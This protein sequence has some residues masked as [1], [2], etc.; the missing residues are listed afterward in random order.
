MRSCDGE[1]NTSYSSKRLGIHGVDTLDAEVLHSNASAN[2]CLS[3]A[4]VLHTVRSDVVNHS[5]TSFEYGDS[6]LVLVY[7][8]KKLSC[9]S[10]FI[11][12]AYLCA[13]SA[14]YYYAY[15]LLRFLWNQS[16]GKGRI[17][18]I[19]V[20][21]FEKQRC[22]ICERFVGLSGLVDHQRDQRA[23]RA[24]LDWYHSFWG[25]MIINEITAF[26]DTLINDFGIGPPVKAW[27]IY[28]AEKFSADPCC[29]TVASIKKRYSD[30]IGTLQA[31]GF[32][33]PVKN[34]SFKQATFEDDVEA[35]EMNNRLLEKLSFEGDC[36]A[37]RETTD[38]EKSEGMTYEHLALNTRPLESIFELID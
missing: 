13:D 31:S 20:D 15:D 38:E 1:Q 36:E 16:I 33:K 17:V 10:G 26:Y 8:A 4:I 2:S 22:T 30:M 32:S 11:M 29:K 12:P 3:P 18:A 37:V 6:S 21:G 25:W 28:L 27:F 14:K 5:S 23:C 7:D 24:I 19:T 35:M 9:G 34:R